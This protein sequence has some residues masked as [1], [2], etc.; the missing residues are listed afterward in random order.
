MPVEKTFMITPKKL[1][2]LVVALA[3][4]ACAGNW[5]AAPQVASK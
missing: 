4:V 5:K 2:M 3:L 1:P